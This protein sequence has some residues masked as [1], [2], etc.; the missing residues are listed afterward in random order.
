MENKLCSQECDRLITEKSQLKQECESLLKEIEQLN[1]SHNSLLAELADI[2]NSRTWLVL[3]KLKQNA[4]LRTIGRLLLDLLQLQF[5]KNSFLSQKSIQQTAINTENHTYQFSQPITLHKYQVNTPISLV[6]ICYNKSQ[7]LPFVIS[8][9]AKN[10]LQPDLIILCDDGST[11]NSLA[12]FIEHC[13]IYNLNY[14]II[15]EPTTKNA[16]RLNTL[17]NKGVSACLD[18]LVIIIDADHVPSRTHIEAHVNLHLSNPHPVLSTGPRLEYANSDCSGAVNFL[19][20]HEPVSM[21]Q[22][23]ADKPIANWTGVLVS[24]MGM[25]KQA[26]INLGSFDPIYDGNYGFDDIDFT[27]RAWLAGYFFASCFE[28]YIIHIPHP[29]SLGNRNNEINR[30]KFENKYNINLKYPHVVERLTRT[31]WHNYLDYLHN[32]NI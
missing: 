2:K 25:S 4:S 32:E 15:Q 29:P 10:T 19:W 14:K 13:N 24:N 5:I 16:F 17:R 26:I 31:S 18:G 9:I 11:D 27:Y 30:R 20:G 1:Q 8:A 21:M 7:E 23:A 3:T 12:V 22:P 28:T 6:I